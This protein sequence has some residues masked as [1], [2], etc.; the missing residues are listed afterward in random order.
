MRRN[1]FRITA[2][3]DYDTT[4]DEADVLDGELWETRIEKPE[5]AKMLVT[6]VLRG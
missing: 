5:F 2:L 3:F 1:S 4:L 6:V